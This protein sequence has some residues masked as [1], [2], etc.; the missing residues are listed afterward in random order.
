MARIYTTLTAIVLAFT[1]YAQQPLGIKN[2]LPPVADAGAYIVNGYNP[3]QME[4]EDNAPKNNVVRPQTTGRLL[5]VAFS[6]YNSGEWT[7][8]TEG[9]L[10]RLLVKLDGAKGIKFVGKVKHL[11][12]GATLSIY[13]TDGSNVVN[14]YT[15]AS[16]AQYPILSSETVPGSEAIIE[17]FEPAGQ[18]GN[19]NF[20][21]EKIGYIY[22]YI[23]TNIPQID[24]FGTSASCHVNVNCPEG[25]AWKAQKRS[26]VRIEILSDLG[27]Q[28][29]TG[30]L[31][32]TTAQDY[33]PYILTA[34]HCGISFDDSSLIN[35]TMFNYWK[36]YFNY[37]SPTCGNPSSEGNL[38][39][40]N[41]TGA[42]VL[43]YSN[44]RGGELGSDFLLLEMSQ[45]VPI[46]FFAYY[47]G[48]DLDTV[49]WLDSGVSIH[50]P[51]WDIKKISTY[52]WPLT[53]TAPYKSSPDKTHWEVLWLKTANGHGVTEGGSSGSPIFNFKGYVVGTLTGGNSDCNNTSKTDVYGRIDWHW[54]KNG[55]TPDRR[56]KNWLDSLNTGKTKMNGAYQYPDNVNEVEQN[57]LVIYPNPA[58]D[59]L[60]FSTTANSYSDDA[61]IT[62]TD[63]MGKQLVSTHTENDGWLNVSTLPQ[64]IYFITVNENNTVYTA[65]FIKQ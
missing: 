11:P 50:H 18:E 23:D 65:K 8:V 20:V 36:F 22:N 3:A 25:D 62:I 49:N 31:M 7:K 43:A 46:D 52:G 24:D 19:A 9:N 53:P 35:D 30:T 55:T 32:N 58:T 21:L 13:N 63:V 39:D 51:K 59:W 15:P 54:T 28:W 37:E 33:K 12:Q 6:P 45:K 42:K 10:W 64:G 41:I 17:Y 1:T 44:D 56:L 38:A 40:Q 47:S 16:F 4:A 48:W 60:H 5:S 57:T 2:N 14:H 34:M 29:C 61:L 27:Q 26:V